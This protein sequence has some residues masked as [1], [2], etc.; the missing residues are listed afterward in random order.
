[1]TGPPDGRAKRR[2]LRWAVLLFVVGAVVA[3]TFWPAPKRPS[4]EGKTVEQWLLQLDPNF[5]RSAEHDRA[6]TALARMGTNALPDLE[7]I[8]GQ[9]LN[10]RREWW[11]GWMIHLHLTKP[12]PLPPHER[13]S[14]A[15]RAAY[16]LAERAKVD[17]RPL[18]PQLTFHFTNA[19]FAEFPR[20][21]AN[22]GDEGISVLTNFLFTGHDALRNHAAYGLHFDFVKKKPQAISALL[23]AATTETNR[24][25]R[26]NALNSLRGTGAPAEEVVPLALELLRSEDAY[27]RWQAAGLLVDYRS[28]DEVD[29]ALG[30]AANDSDERVRKAAARPVRR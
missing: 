27:S 26:A 21:L 1:M 5:A 2:V 17:I 23:R 7:R 15:T 20:A 8:L 29:K 11:K 13:I 14:R 18:L 19:N 9:R 10:E 30:A 22:C 4:Y 12:D 16:M 6:W 25:L 3:V 24:I 28:I